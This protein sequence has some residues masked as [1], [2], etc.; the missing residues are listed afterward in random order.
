M[1][2]KLN[3]K[4]LKRLAES[5]NRLSALEVDQFVGGGTGTKTDPYEYKEMMGLLNDSSWTGGWVVGVDK[6]GIGVDYTGGTDVYYLSSNLFRGGGPEN[7]L[8]DGGSVV[9]AYS[10][11]EFDTLSAKGKWQGGFVDGLGYVSAG[12]EAVADDRVVARY[13]GVSGAI[14]NTEGVGI[15]GGTL[16]RGYTVIENGVITVSVSNARF[17]RPDIES[18]IVKVNAELWVDGECV[19]TQDFDNSGAVIYQT[20]DTPMGFTSFDLHQY[21]GKVEVKVNM[22]L[23]N[24]SPYGNAN[25]KRVETVYSQNR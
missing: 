4:N 13:G 19:K 7:N 8:Y 23:H 16:L 12:G 17:L 5:L 9:V 1:R 21:H 15:T 3:S 18:N 24:Y 6:V 2:K 10:K 20:G 22:Y 25:E 11:K 14:L